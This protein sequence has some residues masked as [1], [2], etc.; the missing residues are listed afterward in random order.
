MKDK[1]GVLSSALSSHPRARRGALNRPG[2]AHRAAIEAFVG[3]VADGNGK[4]QDAEGGRLAVVRCHT[5]VGGMSEH[6]SAVSPQGSPD[7]PSLLRS[8]V[9]TLTQA[10][11]NSAEPAPIPSH[12]SDLSPHPS[13]RLPRQHSRLGCDVGLGNKCLQ[14]AG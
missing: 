11:T 4:E 5:T 9:Q 6:D 14:L 10:P 12:P 1:P 8:D 13:L 3:K 2:R 7:I